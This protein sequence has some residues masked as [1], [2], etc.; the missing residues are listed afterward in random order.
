MATGT[1]RASGAATVS[2]TL[3]YTGGSGDY[4]VLNDASDSTYGN[5]SGTSANALWPILT[6]LP[7]DIATVTAIS[8]TLR[9]ARQSKGD[10]KN[11]TSLQ[12][13]KADG[14]TAISG[15]V[16]VSGQTASAANYTVAPSVTLTGQSD[17]NE[18]QIKLLSDTGT[19]AVKVYEITV[20]I[21]YTAAAV[22]TTRPAA[23]LALL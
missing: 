11:I 22:A 2:G 23:M 8:V 5:L 12:L 9:L 14:T 3:T 7:V 18:V 6:G 17:W 16:A 19:L 15:S 10:V 21:T 1:L 20:T 4:T 13:F